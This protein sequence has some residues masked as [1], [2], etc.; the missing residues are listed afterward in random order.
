M[1][2]EKITNEE[3]NNLPL[4][5]YEGK[6]VVISDPLK[7]GDCFSEINGADFVGFDTETRPNFKK[8]VTHPI[9]LMQIALEKKVF[10]FRL[11]ATGLTNEMLDFFESPAKKVG[12]ALHDD[13]KGL[14]RVRKFKASQF[15]NL[16]DITESAGIHNKGLRKLAGIILEERISKSQQLSNWENEHLT[17]GQIAYAAADAWACWKMYATLKAKG[18]A[19]QE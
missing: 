10:I 5:K 19:D 8:G 3:I 11:L 18:F 2:Q 9:A 16:G 1:Y 12:I 6:T 17:P 13:I 14:Q 15:I 4:L 7:V